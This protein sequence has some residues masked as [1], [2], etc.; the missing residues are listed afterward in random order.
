MTSL[1]TSRLLVL[2]AEIRL[3]IYAQIIASTPLVYEQGLGIT[4]QTIP[5]C[6]YENTSKAR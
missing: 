4:T 3:N 5:Q 1:P 6:D 2:P